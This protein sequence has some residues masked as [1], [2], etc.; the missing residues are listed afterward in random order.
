[1][2]ATAEHILVVEDEAPMRKF[3][4]TALETRGFRVVERTDGAGNEAKQPDLRMLWDS[5]EGG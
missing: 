3:L 4:R 1:M 2:I 5:S